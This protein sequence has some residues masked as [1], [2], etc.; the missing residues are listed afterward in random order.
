MNYVWGLLVQ[1]HLS[2]FVDDVKEGYIPSY[3]QELDRLRAAAG[4]IKV[5]DFA[6]L[7]L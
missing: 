4:A 2:P 3:R 6:M 5:R 1:P 7:L